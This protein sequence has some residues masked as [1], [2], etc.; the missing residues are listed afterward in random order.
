M[1]FCHSREIYL[2]NTG[3]KIDTATKTGLDAR[4]TASKKVVYKLLTEEEKEELVGNKIVDKNVK[5]K[6]VP[7]EN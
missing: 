6:P 5:R 7:D 2:T 3:E 4:R 1:D